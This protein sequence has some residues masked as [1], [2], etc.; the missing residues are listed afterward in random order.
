[1]AA[2]IHFQCILSFRFQWAFSSLVGCLHTPRN[3]LLSVSIVDPL[4]CCWLIC[5]LCLWGSVLFLCCNFCWSI[6][7]LPSSTG[8]AKCRWWEGGSDWGSHF[9][10]WTEAYRSIWHCITLANISLQYLCVALQRFALLCIRLR[11]VFHSSLAHSLVEWLIEWPARSIVQT[12][13]STML[14]IW[15]MTAIW[16][17]LCR[18]DVAFDASNSSC[19]FWNLHRFA[20]PLSIFSCCCAVCLA[21]IT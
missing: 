21:C 5:L 2:F 13:S 20:L 18:A 10:L 17:G 8:A 11:F 9:A 12:N 7:L 1:M 14:E 16:S 3:C 6:A 19:C 15:R 4:I